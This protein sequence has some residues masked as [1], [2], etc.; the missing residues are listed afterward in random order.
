VLLANPTVYVSAN[1]SGRIDLYD[2]IR[3]PPSRSGWLPW[4]WPSAG[5]T[6]SSARPTRS[7][8]RYR[9]SRCP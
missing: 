4:I 6:P 1:N 3:S 5:T 2:E 9:W 7:A 8:T